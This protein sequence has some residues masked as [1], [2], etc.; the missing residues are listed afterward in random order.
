MK[1]TD[2]DRSRYVVVSITGLEP[3]I[4]WTEESVI[5][6]FHTHWFHWRQLDEE[7]RSFKTL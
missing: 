1:W 4:N 5:V 6:G 3:L 2:R 7:V